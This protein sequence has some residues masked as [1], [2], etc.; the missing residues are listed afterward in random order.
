VPTTEVNIW[1]DPAGAAVVR[2][3]AGGNETVP[4]VV[5]GGTVLVN[6]G[7]HQVAAALA[8]GAPSGGVPAGGG[9]VAR[10]RRA[11]GG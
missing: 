11:L 9:W 2:A 5:I 4:T 8:G 6:P 10:A 1:E 7:V 3:A